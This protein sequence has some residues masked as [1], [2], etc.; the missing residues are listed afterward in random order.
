MI[1]RFNGSLFLIIEEFDGTFLLRAFLIERDC[2]YKE[3]FNN[4]VD[5]MRGG[6]VLPNGV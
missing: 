4:Y 5:K 1:E 2:V 6:T 3:P